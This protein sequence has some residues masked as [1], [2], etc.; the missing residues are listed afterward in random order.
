MS[1]P[2]QDAIFKFPCDYPVKA[3]GYS[4]AEFENIV[5]NI[6]GKHVPKNMQKN[7][8]TKLS[9]NGKYISVTI[10]ITAQSRKQLD[11][12][13]IELTEHPDVLYAL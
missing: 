13:Y 1:V 5:T 12:I 3:M 7:L 4:N 10:S 6:L 11:A 2:D 8:R 9:N